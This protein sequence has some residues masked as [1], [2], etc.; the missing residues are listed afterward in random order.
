MAASRHRAFGIFLLAWAVSQG[1]RAPQEPPPVTFHAQTGLVLL[2]FHATHGK[3][4]VTDLKPADVVLL[5]DGKPRGFTIFDSRTIR[6][7]F[8]GCTNLALWER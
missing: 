1:Q 2:S 4:Y 3:N 6:E 8:S 5:E 7:T